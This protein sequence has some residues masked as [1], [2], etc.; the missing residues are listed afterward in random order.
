MS[1]RP[2]LWVKERPLNTKNTKIPSSGAKIL[3]LVRDD[4]DM[5]EPMN[6]MLLSALARR[7]G[8]TS[9]LIV[10][11]R[12][13]LP[14][15]IKRVKPDVVAMSAITGSH[16]A[17]LCANREIKKIDSRI[18]T[19]IGGP[20]ATFHPNVVREEPFD[21]VGIGECDDAWG[22]LLSAWSANRSADAIPNIVTPGNAGTVLKRSLA[23]TAQ[24]QPSSPWKIHPDHLRPRHTAL[25]DLPYLDRDLIYKNTAFGKRYKRTIMAGRGCPFRC[26]YCFEHAWNDMYTGKGAVLQRYSVRRICEELAHLK[27]RWDTRFIKFYDDVF[28]VFSGRDD[29]W[30][31]EF[32]HTY[33]RM[34]GLPFHCLVR[35]ELVDRHKLTLLKAAGAASI[36]MSIEA[37][38]AFARDYVLIRDMSGDDLERAFQI[39]R[40]IR[41]PTFANTILGAPV[42]TLPDI[43]AAQADY[44]KALGRIMTVSDRVDPKRKSPGKRLRQRLEEAAGTASDENGRRAARD[45]ILR[46]IGVRASRLAYDRDSLWANVNYSVGFGEFP[47][48]FPYRGTQLGAFAIESGAFD[49]N[50]DKLHASYQTASPLDC[51]TPQEKREQQNLALLGTIL[52]FFSGS[53][54]PLVYGLRKP[55]AKLA[56]EVLAPLP[57]TGLYVRI[58]SAA[59]N[60]MHATRMYPMRQSMRERLAYFWDNYG[61]DRFKQLGRKRWLGVFRHR[62]DRPGQTLG[63][64]PSI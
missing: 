59:K 3:Y 56:I 1:K 49:G 9:D 50:Y 27:A 46:S 41:L 42:P 14:E 29:A 23:Q 17:L 30:L 36:T 44:D 55:M 2:T 64:P 7:L 18:K 21:A 11:E 35:A 57:L 51:F 40:E 58:Y 37:G 8:H 47:V 6:I 10:L 48:F 33:P 43:H 62:G 25:D 60:H 52:T 31:E 20:F 38:N 12:D 19:V 61:L 53:H 32:A 24:D 4:G 34:V 54:H 63:G 5:T 22:D 39:C 28:P 45:Q 15:T 26:T 13:S 16:Q